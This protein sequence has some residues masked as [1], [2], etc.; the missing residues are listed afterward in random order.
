MN[1]EEVFRV[2]GI[3]E[4]K[5]ER[6]IKNAYREKLTVTNPED[7]PEGFKR[8]RAAFEEAIRLMNEQDEEE[9]EEE[10]DDTPSGQWLEQ[11]KDIYAHMSKRTDIE[12]W[13]ELFQDEVFLSL[14]DEELCTRKLLVFFMDHY[15][16][17]LDVWKLVDKN[18]HF[19]DRAKELREVF[20]ADFVSFLISR[21]DA[22]DFDYEYFDGPDDGDYDRFLHLYEECWGALQENRD[23]EARQLLTDADALEIT[24]PVL[25]ICRAL[26]YKHLGETDK[27]A[28]IM[29]EIA[30]KYPN[31]AAYINQAAE[32]YYS[33]GEE[34][35]DRAAELFMKMKELDDRNYAANLRL[36]EYFFEKKRFKDAKKC[37]ERV[38]QA[39][40][41]D[42]FFE[43]LGQINRELE[44]EYERDW[45][46]THTWQPGL[47]LCWCYLQD[48][49]LMDSLKIT[50]EIES[51][52]PKD[53]EAE[54]KGL[55]SK[56]MLELGEYEE[57]A[58]RAEIWEEALEERVA[59]D[60]EEAEKVKDRDRIRQSHMIRIQCYHHLGFAKEG[61][62]AKAIEECEAITLGNS[63]DINTLLE[64]G[65]IYN[66]MG[67][68]DK[69][70]EVAEMLIENYRVTAAYSIKME[71]GRRQLD[72]SLVHQGASNCI[73]YF[74]DYVKPYEYLGKV[75]MD[76]ERPQDME[77]LVEAAK[78]N[79][80][81]SDLLNAYVYLMDHEGIDT[82]ELA[83]KCKAFREEYRKPLE[84][85]SPEYFEKGL[86][87]IT[88]L[89]NRSPEGYMFVERAI[90]HRMAGHFAEAEKD[91]E[92]ALSL[93]PV[94]FFALN[95]MSFVYKYQGQ[96]DKAIAFLNKAILNKTEKQS[97]IIYSDLS[98]LYSL[99]G[100]YRRA[101][102]AILKYQ[103]LTDD[104]AR[105]VENQ[106]AEVY[107]NLCNAAEACKLYESY[108]DKAPIAAL[109]SSVEASY[110]CNDEE[111]TREYLRRWAERLEI[112]EQRELPF[113]KL[114]NTFFKS[115]NEEEKVDEKRA[116][117]LV[118][119]YKQLFW[120]ELVFNHKRAFVSAL[121]K[122][123]TF[124][125]DNSDAGNFS[126]AIFACICFGE[127]SRGKELALKL[128]A[129]LARYDAN[130]V[131]S[132]YGRDKGLMQLRVLADWYT[133]DNEKLMNML[134]SS[135]HCEI[136]H[137]CTSS[138]C[139]EL[140]CLKVLLYVR[141]GESDKAKTYME[142]CLRKMPA[143]EY[144]LAV[145]H[146]VLPD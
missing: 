84:N 115:K 41:H 55:Y 6:A 62:F 59:G 70:I 15:R 137:F 67:E 102:A 48:S 118:R 144:M 127:E 104:H 76:L 56:I 80:V 110:K 72:A 101:L 111:R 95:A 129:W 134:E 97:A 32:F 74:P 34:K 125:S 143:D 17:P 8:L 2:L 18:V 108:A 24:H 30:E 54:W 98:E 132:Y 16:L 83:E 121:D 79:G 11:V 138:V 5:D 57:S 25:E 109:D 146:V 23:D 44:T 124:E 112:K 107:I 21:S 60:E 10:I 46:D 106:I 119:Y 136:C 31:K 66:D 92:V 87:V 13:K 7:N 36:T 126:D 90:F 3:P 103:E 77:K 142:E 128:K 94:N 69:A 4:T 116:K 35:K 117:N 75:Y 99:A 139:R 89:L 141:M 63:K 82:D 33:L 73:H 93:N 81:K 68:Y 58:R 12:A 51:L 71:A 100:D 49:R 43:L 65:A 39:G 22:A 88:E 78:E 1:K 45:N 47:E 27:S 140:E 96:Y 28:V 42:E 91:L 40:A 122:M 50:E 86:P 61:Y 53:K 145:K 38:L 26:Y 113:D 85:G 123:R 20:P 131:K 14:E 64:K 130:P 105:W 37:A 133:E 120:T 19:L 9:Q 29:D 114:K 52:L 135:K